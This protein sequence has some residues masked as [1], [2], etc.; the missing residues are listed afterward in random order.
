MLGYFS[1]DIVRLL[2]LSVLSS[3]Q[4]DRKTSEELR[5]LELIMSKDK[6]PSKLKG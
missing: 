6:F 4:S 5:T 3:K 1:V 2:T